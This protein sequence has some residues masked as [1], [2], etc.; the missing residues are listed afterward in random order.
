MSLKQVTFINE[1][2]PLT[3]NQGPK[4]LRFRGQDKAMS[5][6]QVTFINEPSSLTK[7]LRFRGQDKAMSLKQV[8]FISEP[9][10]GLVRDLRRCLSNRSLLLMNTTL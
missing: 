6:K 2:S 5:L 4:R 8:T 10:S 1:Q 7:H 3:C 9:S